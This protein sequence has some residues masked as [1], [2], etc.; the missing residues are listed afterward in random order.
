MRK[1]PPF[2]LVHASS[3]D[4]AVALLGAAPADSALYAGG[5]E[6][7]QAMKLGALRYTRLVDVK[8]VPE[9][10]R[11]DVDGDITIGAAVTHRQL[12]SSPD[13]IARVPEVARVVGSL[14]NPRVRA[15]GTVGGN[16]CF[17]EPHSDVAPMLI[18]LDARCA[19]HGGD[20]A[21]EVALEEFIVGP[22]QTVLAPDELLLEVRVPSEAAGRA[23]AYDSIR[24]HERPNVGVAVALDDAAGARV[25]VGAVTGMPVRVAAAEALLAEPTGADLDAAGAAVAEAVEVYDDA[26]GS[27]EYKRHLAATVFRRAFV[28]ARDMHGR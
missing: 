15:T 21:R 28:R 1:L 22:F 8:R 17:A 20:G 14:A 2:E 9:L 10:T 19:V 16:L 24:F 25:V 27:A 23:L 11:L 12:A 13:V 26:D 5:T 6:L 18:A 3:A 4:E 7:L